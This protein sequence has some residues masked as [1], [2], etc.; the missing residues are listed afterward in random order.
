MICT[1][2]DLRGWVRTSLLDFPGRIATVLFTGGC[3]FRCPPCQNAGLVL[4]PEAFPRVEEKE[5]W[6]FLERR[7]GKVEG[8]VLTGGE[9]TLQLDLLPF[10]QRLRETGLEAKLD[11]N[12]YRPEVLQ[13]VLVEG[14]VDYVAM[15]VKAPPEKYP[16]LSGRP[17]LDLGR[18]ER[19]IHLLRNSG[20]PHEFRTTVVPTLLDERDVEAIARWLEGA[21]LY[22]LQ[23]FRPAGTLDP[24]LEHVAP[25]P[26]EWLHAAA[27]RAQLYVGRVEV[28]LG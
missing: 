12:G 18:I 10:L 23:P 24:A 15:D 9:P 26:T 13:A 21:S 8:V 1:G 22:V 16:L 5:I 14:L 17:D 2:M 20:I 4:H 6:A 11:T 28:R 27:E 7:K 3:N 19:S 25:Y